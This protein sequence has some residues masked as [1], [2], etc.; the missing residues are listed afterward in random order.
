MTHESLSWRD[1]STVEGPAGNMFGKRSSPETLVLSLCRAGRLM[2]AR[3]CSWA[4]GY[5]AS[6]WH[7]VA[8][9]EADAEPEARE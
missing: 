5:L 9:E 2:T 4:A 8:W 6:T 3:L 1:P 7:S